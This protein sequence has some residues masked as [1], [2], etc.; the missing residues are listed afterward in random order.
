MPR[1]WANGV[2]R[3]DVIHYRPKGNPVVC[4]ADTARLHDWAKHGDIRRVTCRDCLGWIGRL[5]EAKKSD[6]FA[7]VP[8]DD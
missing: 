2:E 5:L 4:G 8:V 6:P 3:G 1:R 7:T